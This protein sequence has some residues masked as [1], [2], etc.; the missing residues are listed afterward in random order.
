MSAVSLTLTRTTSAKLSTLPI[1]DGQLIQLSDK[2][3][4]FYDSGNTRY[5]LGSN[6]FRINSQTLSFTELVAE[7]S[8]NR[9]TAG[10]I[11]LAM[12]TDGTRDTAKAARITVESTNG[13]VRFTAQNEPTSSIQCDILCFN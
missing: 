1:T 2:A 11:V 6:S 9:V 7:V 10:T 4:W 5:E 12:F 8:D 3:G 13:A